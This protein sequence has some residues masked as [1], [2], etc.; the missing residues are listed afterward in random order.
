MGGVRRRVKVDR[1]KG[2]RIDLVDHDGIRR[3]VAG[4]G[5]VHDEAGAVFRA[6]PARGGVLRKLI[7]HLVGRL[8]QH[9]GFGLREEVREQNGVV[10]AAGDRVVRS[11]GGDE[12]TRDE[13]GAL[14]DQLVERVLAVRAGLAP[15][16][17]PRGVVPDLG[18]CPSHPLS[19][20]FH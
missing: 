14:V 18:T 5:L 8:S 13:L 20:R 4:E 17:G 6:H 16:D 19:V 11:D 12:V 9:E 15:D 10:E 7:P 3:A 1:A 2:R